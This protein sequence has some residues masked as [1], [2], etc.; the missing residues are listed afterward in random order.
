MKVAIINFKSIPKMVKIQLKMMKPQ[1]S[2]LRGQPKIHK[3]DISYRQ[4]VNYMSALNTNYVNTCIK[5]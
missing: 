4:V 1:P 2:T 5:R 3:Q